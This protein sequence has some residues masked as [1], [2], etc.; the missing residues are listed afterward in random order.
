MN[1]S[2]EEYALNLI[3]R[4]KGVKGVWAST[5]RY[6]NQCWTRDFCLTI[7]PLLLLGSRSRS[8]SGSGSQQS[9]INLAK[10]HLGEIIKR[11]KPDGKIP[12]LYL[13]DEKKFLRNKIEKALEQK[14][15]SFMLS[16][17]L[18]DELENLTP[19]TRDSEVL[20]IIAIDQ[21]VKTLEKQNDCLDPDLDPDLDIFIN[22]AAKAARHALEYVKTIL[23]DGLI[24]GADWRDTR[25]D[26]NDKAVLTNACY[27]YK[28]YKIFNLDDEAEKVKEI[29]KRD[30]WN[31]TYFRDY[32]GSDGFD[33]LGNSLTVLYD[34]TTEDQ[35]NSIFEYAMENLST[36]YGFKMTETFLPALNAKENEVMRRDAAV[37]W[38]FIGGFLLSSMI[39]KGGKKWYC[40]AS[41]E[42]DKWEK[43]EGFNEWYCIVEGGGYGSQDQIWSA[44]LYLR[45]KQ[46]L[47]DYAH[48]LK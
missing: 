43:L 28:A 13:D 30:Y 16:R 44:A 20:F 23:K 47:I 7:C 31:G 24:H 48:Q 9:D 27:L 46:N 41:K 38:P 37:I 11:Q 18:D 5:G 29:L 2:K 1:L 14:T 35:M 22:S 10:K 19:H 36:P 39:T 3:E 8:R 45:V 33:I 4:C 12:I 17:Y 6:N 40:I 25:E 26:L 15:M 32:P 21:L 42:F 34:I